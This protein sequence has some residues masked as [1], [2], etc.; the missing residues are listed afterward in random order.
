MICQEPTDLALNVWVFLPSRVYPGS[1]FNPFV[2]NQDLKAWFMEGWEGAKVVSQNSDHIK[3]F[4]GL[5]VPSRGHTM[6]GGIYEIFKVCAEERNGKQENENLQE[7][8]SRERQHRG[9]CDGR[10]EA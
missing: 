10:S 9:D 3:V 5:S 6:P 1:Q 7:G 2:L 4:S 8:K